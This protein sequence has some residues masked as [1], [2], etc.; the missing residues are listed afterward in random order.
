[1]NDNDNHEKDNGRCQNAKKGD[2]RIRNGS[3]SETERFNDSNVIQ[4]GITVFTQNKERDLKNKMKAGGCVADDT[5][6]GL[7]KK[8]Q[9]NNV[10]NVEELNTEEKAMGMGGGE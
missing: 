7:Q 3:E 9:K 6:Y 5:E 8:T 1:M 2:R 4:R 10:R